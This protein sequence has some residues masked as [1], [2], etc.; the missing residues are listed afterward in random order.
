MLIFLAAFLEKWGLFP[1][2]ATEGPW[3]DVKR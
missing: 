2:V 1:L 3:A